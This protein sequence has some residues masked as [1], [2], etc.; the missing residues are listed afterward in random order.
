MEN[1]E[2]AITRAMTA[3]QIL[4]GINSGIGVNFSDMMGTA[5]ISMAG[6][7]SRTQGMSLKSLDNATAEQLRIK[8]SQ[9]E[10]MSP[11]DKQD[12]MKKFSG[13]LIDDYGLGGFVNPKTGEA[14]F[15]RLRAGLDQRA[16]GVFRTGTSLADISPSLPGYK[17]LATGKIGLGE[18]QSDPK[19]GA[20][21]VKVG[22]A[23][24][25]QGI[26][27]S[28]FLSR[29][30]AGAVSETA[31]GKAAGLMS[32]TG[33][34]S[35]T[36]KTLDDMATVQFAEM[37]KEAKLAADQLGGVT[38][39]LQAMNEASKAL[40]DKVGDSNS[41][42]IMGASAEAAKSFEMG[43]DTF[44]TGVQNFGSILN[45][46]ARNV[47]VRVPENTQKRSAGN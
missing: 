38:K 7:V 33:P 24:R 23:A 21:R 5:S 18:L 41:S 27:T 2:M 29:G 6:G 14:D 37:S 13:S 8:M 46:F 19:Y 35:E 34:V 4:E 36:K 28:E 15:S 20:L 30:G 39:A 26:T 12:A 31:A 9:I 47:G 11:K 22:E 16:M 40:A 1:K 45:A 3:S 32:G 17:D 44:A 42:T 10:K 25:L 43:A